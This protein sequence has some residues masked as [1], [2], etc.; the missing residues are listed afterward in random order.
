MGRRDGE[1]DKYDTD[2]DLDSQ[3]ERFGEFPVLNR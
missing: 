3:S 1:F 2:F